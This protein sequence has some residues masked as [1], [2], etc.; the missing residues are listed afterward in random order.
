MEDESAFTPSYLP[1]RPDF[2]T[3]GTDIKL[4]TNCF[5]ISVSN[6]VIYEHQMDISSGSGYIPISLKRRILQLAEKSSDWS[7]SGLEGSV[8]YDNRFRRLVSTKRIPEYL[9]IVVT[10]GA[11]DKSRVCV[12]TLIFIKELNTSDLQR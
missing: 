11:E 3:I 7:Q 1:P 10:L 2:G 4:R 5:P 9:N 8:A 6:D 12:L